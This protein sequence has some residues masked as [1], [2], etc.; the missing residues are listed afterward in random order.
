MSMVWLR[1]PI[2]CVVSVGLQMLNLLYILE[3]Y[4]SA[5][6]AMKHDFNEIEQELVRLIGCLEFDAVF[7]WL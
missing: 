3:K 7:A 2:E 5:D 4:F 6:F 1:I